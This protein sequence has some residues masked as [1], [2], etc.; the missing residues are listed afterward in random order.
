MMKVGYCFSPS[1]D[2]YR[3]PEA[4]NMYEYREYIKTLPCEMC[5]EH[6]GIPCNSEKINN[7]KNQT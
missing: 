6:L 3:I 5:P 7:I 2:L 1:C 4:R